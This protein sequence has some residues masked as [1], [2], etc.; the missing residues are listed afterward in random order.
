MATRSNAKPEIDDYIDTP[1]AREKE[2]MAEQVKKND[3]ID[4]IPDGLDDEGVQRSVPQ[5]NGAQVSSNAGLSL[6]EL[7]SLVFDDDRDSKNRQQLDLP[8]GDW[9]KS[10]RWEMRHMVYEGDCMPG[11]INPAGRTIFTFIGKPEPRTHNSVEYC[12]TLILRISPDVRYSRT[13]GKQ[14]EFDNSHKLYLRAKEDLY[15]AIHQEKVRTGLQLITM[16][17][18]DEYIVRTMNGTYG[19]VIIVGLKD[20]QRAGQRRR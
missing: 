17:T 16:L 4:D 8:S 20:K 11:D 18:D 3:D 15:V 5:S 2:K 14:A 7:N 19:N 9:L 6:D 1:T 13:E 10:E 12:P